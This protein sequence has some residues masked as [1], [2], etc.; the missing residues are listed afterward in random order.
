MLPIL[1]TLPRRPFH[2]CTITGIVTPAIAASHISCKKNK[3]RP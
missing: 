3:P 1:T 2:K